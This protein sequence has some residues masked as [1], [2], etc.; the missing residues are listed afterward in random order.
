MEMPVELI[1][2]VKMDNASATVL[3]L[4]VAIVVLTFCQTKRTVAHVVM[5]ALL[6]NHALIVNVSVTILYQCV[7]ILVLTTSLI[8]I[9]VEN[10][11]T[12]VP[13]TNYVKAETV[14]ARVL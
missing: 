4:N 13:P 1:N 8:P 6:I 7:L 11:E 9:T 2:L 3:S 5:P 10:V 12:L 14:Y